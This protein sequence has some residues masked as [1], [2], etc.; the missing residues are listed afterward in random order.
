MEKKP[1]L[2]REAF[3]AGF[4]REPIA[5]DLPSLGTVYYKKASVA[6]RAAARR[7]ASTKGELQPEEFE[8]ALIIACLVEPKLSEMD[9]PQVLALPAAEVNGLAS[10][11]TGV[12]A[13][14][15]K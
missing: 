7:M 15:Q 5:Y 12:G 14:P 11:I 8:A 1:A 4:N 13:N 6:D 10:A 9:M 3:L 2:T